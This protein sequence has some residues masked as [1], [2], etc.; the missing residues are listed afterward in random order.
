MAVLHARVSA[1]PCFCSESA[2][3]TLYILLLV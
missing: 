2:E 3:C 1:M